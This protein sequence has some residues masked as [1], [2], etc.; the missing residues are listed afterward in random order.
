[1][2]LNQTAALNFRNRKNSRHAHRPIKHQHNKPRYK[3]AFARF[4]LLYL[5]DGVW[6]GER[7][8]P[9]GWAKYVAA[10][11]P[12]QPIFP[13]G[14]GYDAQFWL[15]GAKQGL[16]EGVFTADGARGQWAMI[17]PSENMVIV[18]RGH[19]HFNPSEGFEPEGFQLPRFA[20]D[21]LAAMK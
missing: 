4:G 12:D 10:P 21:V 2:W 11:G 14:R 20:A 9:E 18:R 7:I 16:P 17:I 6:N 13:D 3:R 15:Y 1:M 5:N 19:D 8:L